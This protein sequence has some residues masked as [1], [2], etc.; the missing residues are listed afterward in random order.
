MRQRERKEE[1]VQEGFSTAMTEIKSISREASAS[2]SGSQYGRSC[3][4]T[5]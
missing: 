2:H 3:R 4:Q 1:T 5:D